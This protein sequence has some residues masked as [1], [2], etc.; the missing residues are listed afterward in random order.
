MAKLQP[1][2][3]RKRM[4][5]LVA[6]AKTLPSNGAGWESSGWCRA[7]GLGASEEAFVR[8]VGLQEDM[9]LVATPALRV[10]SRLRGETVYQDR[11]LSEGKMALGRIVGAGGEVPRLNA[12]LAAFGTV[13]CR[14]QEPLCGQC[15]VSDLCVSVKS[16][17]AM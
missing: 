8:A 1:I 12:A 14:A 13:V 10:I 11:P 5:R 9:V 6:A 15:P 16:L 3:V 2:Q 7:G 17:A 4:R